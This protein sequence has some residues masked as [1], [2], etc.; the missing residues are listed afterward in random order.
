LDE[1]VFEV[2]GRKPQIHQTAYIGPGS[3]IFGD[4][5]VQELAGIWPG[6]ILRA[7]GAKIVVGKSSNVQDNTVVHGALNPV[8]IGEKVTIGHSSVLHG[9]TIQKGCVVGIAAVILD[10]AIVGEESMVGAGAIV[11]EGAAI[12]PRTL[13]LGVP[14]KPVRELSEEDVKRL[15]ETTAFYA[16]LGQKYKH[17]TVLSR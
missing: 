6:A 7:D 8:T 9:C 13:V 5:E 3:K 1:G 17:K 10:R 4:V 2:D 12:P 15:Y 11:L 14:A 16:N